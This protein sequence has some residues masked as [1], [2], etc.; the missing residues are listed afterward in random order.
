MKLVKALST[1]KIFQ[2]FIFGHQTSTSAY[3]YLIFLRNLKKKSILT[4][5]VFQTRNTRKKKI[6]WIEE[7]WFLVKFLKEHVHRREN[8]TTSWM[9]FQH[10]KLNLLLYLFAM[11]DRILQCCRT[12]INRHF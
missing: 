3:S 8:L 7:I 1:I 11:P 10:D 2:K 9:L 5:G 4:L 6:S 12:Q